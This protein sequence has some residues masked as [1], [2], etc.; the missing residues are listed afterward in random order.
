M[1]RQS[2]EREGRTV[3]AVLSGTL[4]HE[5]ALHTQ[6]CSVC[7][8]ILLVA[9]FLQSNHSLAD[10]ERT[11]LPDPQLIWRRARFQA[12]QDA[13]RLAL[14]PIRFMTIMAC[15]AFAFSPWLRVLLPIG[16]GLS[17]SSSRILDSTLASLS[18]TSLGSAAVVTMFFGFA[19]TLIL[20]GLSSW[21]MLRQE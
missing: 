8:D 20:L 14:R 12:N 1:N 16:R 7:S 17:I 4:D 15:V 21:Y 5:S 9:G 3:T 18:K 10:H 11:A 2:C 13:V 6:Q 19:G